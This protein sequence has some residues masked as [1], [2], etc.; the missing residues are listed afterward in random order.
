M[1]IT[2]I[3]IE[4]ASG[5]F[6]FARQK[7]L[8]QPENGST[9]P[10]SEVPDHAAHVERHLA[11]MYCK[12]IKGR[13]YCCLKIY[14]MLVGIEFKRSKIHSRPKASF[15]TGNCRHEIQEGFETEQE[16]GQQKVRCQSAED[17]RRSHVSFCKWKVF[18]W[19]HWWRD[20]SSHQLLPRSILETAIKAKV[21]TKYILSCKLSV[22]DDGLFFGDWK[23]DYYRYNFKPL[24]GKWT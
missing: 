22:M 17:L 20:R 5:I 24:V 23:I 13:S 21:H 4:R 9:W 2:T 3:G 11:A 7:V 18:Y 10:S 6:A 16:I 19:S 12:E 15:A 14:Q 1:F 8:Q